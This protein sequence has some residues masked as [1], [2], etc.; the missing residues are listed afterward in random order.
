MYKTGAAIQLR[1]LGYKFHK[2][3]LDRGGMKPIN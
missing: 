2:V 3:A 1:R